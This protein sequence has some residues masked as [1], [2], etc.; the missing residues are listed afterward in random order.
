MLLSHHLP[1]EVKET[2]SI[3]RSGPVRTVDKKEVDCSRAF[4]FLFYC[5]Q[6]TLLYMKLQFVY[7]ITE[8][9]QLIHYMKPELLYIMST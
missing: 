2:P 8:W 4:D 9:W 7:R 6:Y 3:C 5:I 1:V